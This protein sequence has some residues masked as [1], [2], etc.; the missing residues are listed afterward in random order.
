MNGPAPAKAP[1]AAAAKPV[2]EARP[3]VAAPAGKG[4]RRAQSSPHQSPKILL[5]GGVRSETLPRR[6]CS[7][8]V[9]KGEACG[10]ACLPGFL[11]RSPENLRLL[12]ASLACALILTACRPGDPS[13]LYAA[14][15]REQHYGNLDRAVSA[16]QRGYNAWRSEPS[17][18]WHWRFRLL[19]ADLLLSA[20]TP[21]EALPLLEERVP[22][23]FERSLE[24]RRQLFLYD[25]VALTRGDHAAQPYLEEAGRLA[26]GDPDLAMETE[27]RLATGPIDAGQADSRLRALLAQAEG[28]GDHR[29]VAGILIDIGYLYGTGGRFD[30]ALPFL[31]RSRGI[32]ASQGLRRLLSRALGSLGWCTYRLGELDEALRLTRQADALAAETGDHRRRYRWINNLGALHFARNELQQAAAQYRLAAGLAEQVQTPE[33]VAIALNNLTETW[34][35]VGN[36]AAA[37]A[38]NRKALALIPATDPVS[39]AFARIREARIAL[40]RRQDADAERILRRVLVDPARPDRQVDW[41]AW[42]SLAGLYSRTARPDEADAAFRSG[43][44]AVDSEWSR[45]SDEQYRVTF[46]SQLA[47]DFQE[48]VDFLA[49]QGRDERALEIADSN[50]ARVLARRFEEALPD[51]P[52]LPA[53]EMKV[54]ARAS[55]TAFLYYS[56]ASARSHLWVVTASRITRLDLAAGKDIADMARKYAAAVTGAHD[57]LARDNPFAARLYE[58]LVAPAQP[59]LDG[60]ARVIV[61][62][63][64]P[65]HEINLETLI[66][67][68][69]RPHF[70]LEDVTLEIAPSLA[71]LRREVQPKFSPRLL[72][73]GD[74]SSADSAF[75]PLPQLAREA[76]TVSRHFS[77][78]ALRTGEAARPGAYREAGPSGFTHIHFAAHAVPNKDSPLNSAIILSRDGD[79]YKLYAKDILEVPI[80]ARL[81]TLS[82]CHAAGAK[83]YSGEGLMGFSWAF[84]RAGAQNVIASLWQV[85]D[86]AAAALMG[87]LYAEMA[88][89]RSPAEALRAAKLDL[90]RSSDRHKAPYY[91]GA[92]ELFTRELPH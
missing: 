37:E 64:G 13:A 70:W 10:F 41:I 11:L 58:T 26:A 61:I 62:P 52:P 28:R 54:M 23:R 69:P 35:Q 53:A 44:A 79:R 59:L 45:L 27:F 60:A 77:R 31:E 73:V 15:E 55:G 89:G 92:F 48:Y 74:P 3:A 21:A 40:A 19:L 30:Q 78:S 82:A 56:I 46:L 43:L 32:A 63:D 33:W 5:R 86:Q 83:A 39:L 42:F 50:R 34:L 90:L 7:A 65:L 67:P 72:L 36:L 24:C 9:Y 75:P 17:S 66:V 81:V 49:S 38:E 12:A 20:R 4:S 51:T 6:L 88:L 29:R 91:W 8:L 71:S 76:A 2:A 47:D 57:T 18:E 16:A 80:H 68:G 85:D 1:E 84:L 25:A 87:R 22:S 14:A